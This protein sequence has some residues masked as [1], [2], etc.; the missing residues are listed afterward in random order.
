[1]KTKFLLALV[2][3]LTVGGVCFG[4]AAW[5]AH[6]QLVT[7]DVR[8]RPLAEVLR[9]IEWQTWQ[10]IRAEESLLDVRVS[11]R[12]T[13]KPLP[14]VLDRLAA[15]AGAHWSILFAVYRSSAAL[16]GLDATLRRDGRLE[17]AGWTKIAPPPPEANTNA[18]TPAGLPPGR[19]QFLMFRRTG[20]G[21]TAIVQD[22][23]GHVEIWSP[24]ELVLESALTAR[25]GDDRNPD[26]TASAAAGM[27]RRMGG[28]WSTYFAFAK[29]N[30][31]MRVGGPPPV[32]DGLTQIKAGT[33]GPD[34]RLAQFPPGQP[35]PTLA[36]PPAFNPNDRFAN[37]TPEGRVQFARERQQAGLESKTPE[38]GQDLPPP[39]FHSQP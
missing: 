32:R 24:E 15:Q 35:G 28:R 13:Q 25:L 6:R 36:S 16:K 2:A 29:S 17:P 10:K 14:Y 8:E 33:N 21:A 7:L 38:P 11:L 9:K 23:H 4:W 3:L 31:G 26:A 5:R 22:G 1:M 19:G 39:P 27:A 37:F 30:I 18:P 20:G 34:D 12:V